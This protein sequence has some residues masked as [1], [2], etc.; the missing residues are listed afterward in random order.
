M[1]EWKNRHFLITLP[2][3]HLL[4]IF[5]PCFSFLSILSH[6]MITILLSRFVNGMFF[7]CF[8]SLF[9]FCFYSYYF[10]IIVIISIDI[11][12]HHFYQWFTPLYNRPSQYLFFH[13]DII[14]C[15]Y[16]TIASKSSKNQ[17]TKIISSSIWFTCWYV[18]KRNCTI[19]VFS[20]KFLAIW[21]W[22][23]VYVFLLSS[24][25]FFLFFFLFFSFHELINY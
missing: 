11:I 20:I 12:L 21:F 3:H 9:P 19:F 10:V 1:I 13:F 7:V 24:L 18:T 14:S 8:F 25:L 22:V 23:Y 6:I 4:C 5:I 15:F 16:S 2:S 17:S